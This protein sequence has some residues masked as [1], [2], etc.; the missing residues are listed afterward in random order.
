MKAVILNTQAAADAAERIL[1]RI[2]DLPEDGS[3][4]PGTFVG[5]GG[6]PPTPARTMRYADIVKHPTLARWAV[7][8]RDRDIARLTSAKAEARLT[9]PAKDADGKDVPSRLTQAEYDTL[10][11]RLAG[12][13]DL[14]DGWRPLL[15][16]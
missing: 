9:T 2:H 16:R 1:R 3:G 15:V 8:F 5:G 11:T 10:K 4:V 12:A 13:V 14:P 7:L 6:H